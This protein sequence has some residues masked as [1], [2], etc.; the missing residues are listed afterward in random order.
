[1]K[2]TGEITVHYVANRPRFYTW[3][4]GATAFLGLGDLRG[5]TQRD[6][7]KSGQ[8]VTVGGLRVCLLEWYPEYA[9]WLVSRADRLAL[10][11]LA[12]LRLAKAKHEASWRGRVI[13]WAL[14]LASDPYSGR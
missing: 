7:Y 10:I 8:I 14:G 9:S 6:V 11:R 12:R 1:M 4:G 2:P 5:A 13:L 3:A